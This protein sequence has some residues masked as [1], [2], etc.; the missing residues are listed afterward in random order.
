MKH[1]NYP[2]FYLNSEDI[3]SNGKIINRD[4]PK[5]LPVL[6]MI[7]SSNC[8]WCQKAKPE[9]QKFANNFGYYLRSNDNFKNLY[10]KYKKNVNKELVFVATAKPDDVN[11]NL[12]SKMDSNFQGFP[13]FVI[14]YKGDKHTYTGKRT[15]EGLK[16]FLERI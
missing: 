1:L 14:Y 5:D 2:I 16:N 11:S 8:H 12:F 3:D 15:A 10:E 4:I 6:V 13:H 7:Q 9:F